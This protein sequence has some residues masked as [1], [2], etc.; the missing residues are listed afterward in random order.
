[1]TYKKR[2]IVQQQFAQKEALLYKESSEGRERP[3]RYQF[4]E[5][6]D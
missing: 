4:F 3:E 1:L 6:S 2:Q 5:W